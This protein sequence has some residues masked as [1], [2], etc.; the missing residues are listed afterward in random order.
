MDV[1]TENLDVYLEGMRRTVELT[2]LSFAIAM[3]LGTLVAAARVSPVPPLRWAAATYVELIRN[4]PLLVLMFMMVFGLPSIGLIYSFYVSA[5]VVLSAYTGTFVA[6]TVRSGI[7]AVSVGQGEAARSLGLTFPQMLR[8]VVLP[9]A[10]RTVIAPLGSIF[11]ALIKNSA[12]AAAIS[13][14]ELTAAAETLVTLTAQPIPAFL[15]AAAAYLMLTIPSGVA[16][17]FLERRFAIK[18]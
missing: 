9:Q 15:G 11:I 17:G 2:L 1:V 3:V 5:I 6:E 14:P 10:L 7:N 12:L 13:V 18:R 8:I 4:T 16:F